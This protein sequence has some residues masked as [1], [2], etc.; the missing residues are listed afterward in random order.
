MRIQA[1]N[2]LP[3]QLRRAGYN[4][5]S[6]GAENNL[7]RQRSRFG[8]IRMTVVVFV[9]LRAGEARR[10]ARGDDR[11]LEASRDVHN[12]RE[13]VLDVRD[14]QV[15]RARRENQL[16]RDRVAEGNDAVVSIHRGEPRAADPV[17]SDS[18]GAATL[19]E[20]DKLFLAPDLDDLAHKE[21]QMTVNR[22]VD[23]TLFQRADVRLRRD[24][25]ADAKETVRRERRADYS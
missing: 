17:E 25:V 24:A 16:R 3:L 2:R 5:E 11:R 19:R 6:L 8:D 15:K 13:N 4:K 12:R 7:F 10:F 9:T 18:L 20:F 22:D 21:R 1:K 23:A 14:P